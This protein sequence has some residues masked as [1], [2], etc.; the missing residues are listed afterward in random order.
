M[1]ETKTFHFHDFGTFG[2]VPE[3]QNQYNFL[4]TPGHL[5]KSKNESQ[6]IFEKYHFCKYQR[7]GNTKTKW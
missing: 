5:N 2:R 6:I 4:E 7:L 3:P 1:G